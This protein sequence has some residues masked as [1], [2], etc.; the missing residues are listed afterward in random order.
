LPCALA[1]QIGHFA[2][3]GRDPGVPGLDFAFQPSD[4]GLLGGDHPLQTRH[5]PL[6][7]VH[8]GQGG[9]ELV[10][11]PVDLAPVVV[12]QGR[13]LGLEEALFLLVRPAEMPELLRVLVVEV[14]EPLLVARVGGGQVGLTLLLPG[15]LL[16]TPFLLRAPKLAQ[17]TILGRGQ[18]GVP[19]L[20]GGGELFLPPL[21]GGGELALASVLRR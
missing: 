15:L 2:P 19:L 20:L 8:P 21:V 13:V 9:G 10:L 12:D 18:L 3:K 5:I 6:Q 1:L 7:G 14:L 11:E 16:G 17:A 4:L